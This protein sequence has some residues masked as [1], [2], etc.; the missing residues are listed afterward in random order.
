MVFLSNQAQA[1]INVTLAFRH[2]GG[3][4]MGPVL[5]WIQHMSGIEVLVILVAAGTAV[6][7]VFLSLMR[8]KTYVVTDVFDGEV[9]VALEKGVTP[10]ER[11]RLLKL[12]ANRPPAV[13]RRHTLPK[14]V[15]FVLRR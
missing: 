10:E 2:K 15:R 11:D 3:P 9:E 14:G 1:S 6:V 13:E 5:T 12:V 4:H 7:C 8:G